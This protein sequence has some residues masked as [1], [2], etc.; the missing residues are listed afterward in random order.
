MTII[1]TFISVNVSCQVGDLVYYSLSS[2]GISGTNNPLSTNINTKVKILGIC[3]GVT[4]TTITVDTSQGGGLGVNPGILNV[5]Y[6][7]QKDKRAGVSGVLGYYAL[8]EYRNYS[9]VPAEIFAT[10]ADYV[11]SSK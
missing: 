5:T 3:I 2:G 1:L 9:T 4:N 7:F 11:E 8:T 6:M 10:S